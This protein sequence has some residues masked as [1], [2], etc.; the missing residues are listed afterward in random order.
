MM[1]GSLLNSLKHIIS[2]ADY[3][4]FL[5]AIDVVQLFIFQEPSQLSQL[6][7][8]GLTDVILYALLKKNVL[9]TVFSALCLNTAGLDAFIES[10]PFDKLFQVVITVPHCFNPILPYRK[11]LFSVS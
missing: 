3:S 10:K 11:G 1:E 9:R 2:N 7:E 6:Q 4:L 5:L 8:N